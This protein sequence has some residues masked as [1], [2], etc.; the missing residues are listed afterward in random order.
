VRGTRKI[1]KEN[2]SIPAQLDLLRAYAAIDGIKIAKNTSILKPPW[3]PAARVDL[4]ISI[5]SSIICGP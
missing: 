3:Q 4:E 2:F 1:R 5:A